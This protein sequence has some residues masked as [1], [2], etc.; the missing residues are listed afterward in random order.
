MTEELFRK[1]FPK[2]IFTISAMTQGL[3]RKLFPKSNLSN[4]IWNS[5]LFRYFQILKK[6]SGKASESWPELSITDKGPDFVQSLDFLDQY[7]Q[8]PS[9]SNEFIISKPWV[10]STNN[11]IKKLLSGKKM[12]KNVWQNFVI[13]WQNCANVWQNIVNCQIF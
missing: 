13:V 6:V 4:K 2:A 3:F 7:Y 5:N 8:R 11:R 12:L 9:T 10:I 1:F